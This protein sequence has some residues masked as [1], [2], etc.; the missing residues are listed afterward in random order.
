[1]SVW[2]TGHFKSQR[3]LTEGC[4]RCRQLRQLIVILKLY[5]F[6][7]L[8]GREFVELCFIDMNALGDLEL[9]IKLSNE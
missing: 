9:T 3:G 1:M 8:A 6:H 5:C 4:S 7:Q 2:I